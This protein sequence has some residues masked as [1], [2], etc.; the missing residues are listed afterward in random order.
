MTAAN[1][2]AFVACV[3]RTL[4]GALNGTGYWQELWSYRKVL[5]ENVKRI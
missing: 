1:S 4:K 5:R 2:W 3:A